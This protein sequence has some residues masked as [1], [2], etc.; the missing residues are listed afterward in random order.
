MTTLP[1]LIAELEAADEGTKDLDAT[2]HC[3]LKGAWYP[4]ALTVAE[5]VTTSIDAAVV[6]CERLLPE[7]SWECRRSGFGN[8]QAD[9]WNP[10]K[11]PGTGNSYRTDTGNTPAIALVIAAL[12]AFEAQQ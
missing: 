2:I 1:D 11:S 10:L 8:S 5:P 12:K 9:V 7:W 4:Y 3:V 6:L